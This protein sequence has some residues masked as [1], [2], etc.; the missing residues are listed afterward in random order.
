MLNNQFISLLSITFAFTALL[1]TLPAWADE[2]IQFKTKGE[3]AYFVN[4]M[5]N[6]ELTLN[7]G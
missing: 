6:P 1:S 3:P 4:D 7:V 2:I 5:Q